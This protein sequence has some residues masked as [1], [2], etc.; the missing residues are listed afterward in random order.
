MVLGMEE[1]A[2][3]DGGN[4]LST[5]EFDACLAIV[6]CR[7]GSNTFA[8]LGQIVGLY[9]GDARQIWDRSKD[10]GPPEGE[11]YEMKPLTRI[12]RVPDEVC[13]PIEDDGVHADHRAAVVHYLLDM[14]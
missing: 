5:D 2:V 4:H 8:H 1:R 13:G 9:R 11:T 12:H 14:G 10:C 3:R 6:V 7:I